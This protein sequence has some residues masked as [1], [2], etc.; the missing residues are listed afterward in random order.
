MDDCDVVCFPELVHKEDAEGLYELTYVV[1]TT[2]RYRLDVRLHGCHVPGSPFVVVCAAAPAPTSPRRARPAAVVG[3]RF[4][5]KPAVQ[6]SRPVPAPS[7]AGTKRPASSPT[8]NLSCLQSS[9]IRPS[10]TSI[11]QLTRPF[12]P[13][14]SNPAVAAR[15]RQQTSVDATGPAGAVSRASRIPSP[16][17]RIT[18]SCSRIV[19]PMDVTD[20]P[21][22][23]VGQLTRQQ[24]CSAVPSPPVAARRQQKTSVDV[25][26]QA[27]VSRVSRIPSPSRRITRSYH[28]IS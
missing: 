2:G 13:Q 5:S 8:S 17:R 18:R 10:S 20:D 28:I 14:A 4:P 12:S 9:R 6:T 27:A 25:A 3:R 23:S 15:R 19:A 24:R 1:P 21:P 11:G 16:S 7:A 26:G 22:T